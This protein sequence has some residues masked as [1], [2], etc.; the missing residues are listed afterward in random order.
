M[1]C[2]SVVS[3]DQRELVGRLFACIA[4]DRCDAI[5]QV[6]YT[7]NVPEGPLPD[8][9]DAMP[10]LEVVDNAQRRGFGANHNAAFARCRQPYFCVLNPDIEWARDPFAALLAAFVA[11]TRDAPPSAT[12]RQ[13]TTRQA[14]DPQATP[15]LGLVAPR[16]VAPGGQLQNTAR[17]LYTVGEMIGQ[18]LHPANHGPDADW[19]AGMFMLFR[20]DAYRKI[21]GFDPG[22]FLY[23]ED[24]DICSRLQLAGWSL[25]QVDG[26]EVVHRARSS[27]HRSLR[28]ASWHLGGMLR[29][30]TG[31]SFWQHRARLRAAGRTPDLRQPR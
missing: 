10:G 16:V 25:A 15:P 14:T 6:I 21:G 24:V 26:A 9:A 2:V 17:R 4:R 22:Y 12:T 28:Y 27:S 18:K 29:Y 31:R 20:S 30:W 11:S 3:H 23:I 19:L 1:I 13:A 7:R 8:G 5:A